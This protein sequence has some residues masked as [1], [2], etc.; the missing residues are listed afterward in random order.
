MD[1]DGGNDATKLAELLLSKPFSKQWSEMLSKGKL[2]GFF[3]QVMKHR[4][5]Q[6]QKQLRQSCLAEGANLLPQARIENLAGDPSRIIVGEASFVRGELLVF[7]FG[8]T[9]RIGAHC[10]LGENSRVWAGETVNIGDHVLISH[11]VFISD[12]NAHEL[13]PLERAEGFKRIVSE[14]HPKDKGSVLTAPV[15]IGTHAWINPQC[16]ILPGVTIGEGAIIGA[17]SVV[18]Q[19]IPS[20]VLAVGN[21]A[22]VIR[23]LDS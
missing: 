11:D 3:D 12:C 23:R 16:V 14:G 10:Y 19:D 21:P 22:R 6:R 15:T 1:D 8:G 20:G 17:G 9:L 7:R 13:D 2:D 18:T 5:S 4:E